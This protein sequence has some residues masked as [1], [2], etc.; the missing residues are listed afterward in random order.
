[1]LVNLRLKPLMI[2]ESAIDSDQS[3]VIP[4]MLLDNDQSAIE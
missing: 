3:T 4:E 1:M 2:T